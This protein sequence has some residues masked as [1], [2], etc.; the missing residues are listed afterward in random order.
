MVDDAIACGA[1]LE[2]AATPYRVVRWV[3]DLLAWCLARELTASVDRTTR[4]P[5]L[6]HDAGYCRQ[7]Q[8]AA[9]SV[10]SHIAEGHERNAPQEYVRV[11]GL[12]TASCADVRSLR[13]IGFG[14]GLLAPNA[15]ASQLALAEQDGQAIGALRASLL[16]CMNG[17][18]Q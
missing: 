11:L 8:R 14:N 17:G 16:R 2:E 6:R 18:H 13:Y 7:V 9:E 15:L 12:A 1:V 3:E 10:M 5:L 4:D